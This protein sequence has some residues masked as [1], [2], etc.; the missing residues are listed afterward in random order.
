[1]FLSSAI[2]TFFVEMLTVTI[3]AHFESKKKKFSEESLEKKFELRLEIT[4]NR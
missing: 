4:R 1:M 2:L 3:E